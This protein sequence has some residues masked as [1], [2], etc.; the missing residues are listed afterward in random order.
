[1]EREKIKE[2][3]ELLE[4]GHDVELIYKESTYTISRSKGKYFISGGE[5][6]AFNSP[7]EVL[8][9]GTING[10]TLKDLWSELTIGLIY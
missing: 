3:E 4:I 6:K 1:M 9:Y 5:F 7:M 8:N 10:I 2:I